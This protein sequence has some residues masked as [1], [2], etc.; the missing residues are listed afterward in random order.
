MGAV[1]RPDPNS[2]INKY[3]SSS[4]NVNLQNIMQQPVVVH[5][6]LKSFKIDRTTCYSLYIASGG[7]KRSRCFRRV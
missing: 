7:S 4:A 5:I 6:L 3:I 1:E 2:H